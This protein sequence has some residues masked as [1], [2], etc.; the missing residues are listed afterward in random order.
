MEEFMK[1]KI[2]LLLAIT[3]CL[4][5]VGC[6]SKDNNDSPKENEIKTK[7]SCT[8]EQYLFHSRKRIGSTIYL[9]KN[10]KLVDYEYF[11]DYYEF[12]S[13]DEFNMICEGSAEEEALNN[14][15][16]EYLNQKANCNKDTRVVTITN[17]YDMTK[18]PSKNVLEAKYVISN[19]NDD[20]I[21]DLDNYKSDVDTNGYTCN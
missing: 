18:I 19:L 1:N 7:L 2:I 13:D 14:R 4:T 15:S 9:D 10:N 6:G 5:L 11:E 16:Y 3:I 12:D 20:Y 8:K 17:K 21:L